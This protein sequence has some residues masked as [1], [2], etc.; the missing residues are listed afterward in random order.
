MSESQNIL[1]YLVGSHAKV[2][3]CG[4]LLRDSNHIMAKN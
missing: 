2:L 4:G 1:K 3:N